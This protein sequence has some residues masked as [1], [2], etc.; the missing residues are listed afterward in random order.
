MKYLVFI[1]VLFLL[2]FAVCRNFFAEAQQPGQVQIQPDS[3]SRDYIGEFTYPCGRRIL[4]AAQITPL[5]DGQCQL[6]LRYFDKNLIATISGNSKNDRLNFAQQISGNV[7]SAKGDPNKI[8]GSVS[9]QKN[10]E[11]A[12][13][14]M[15]E[16]AIR[17]VDPVA[18]DYSGEMTYGCGRKIYV[19]ANVIS[20]SDKQF[21]LN[22]LLIDRGSSV[23]TLDA[24]S[25]NGPFSFE[26]QVKKRHWQ[27]QIDQETLTGSF[28]GNLS[29]KFILRK[30][31]A[32]LSA[33]TA[34]ANLAPQ[35]T[36]P[37]SCS[38]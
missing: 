34:D 23:I 21:Q 32:N 17:L 20:P 11:F 22:L 29:G 36:D 38:P 24:P 2:T 16:N 7:W 14:R 8:T 18:A 6:V 4:L 27:A 19:Y 1:S 25:Q 3:F 33:S 26:D 10:G 15:S 30:G 5:A 37:R 13:Y 9:G 28:W 31:S 12:L 35:K